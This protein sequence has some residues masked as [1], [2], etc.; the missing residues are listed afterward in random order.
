MKKHYLIQNEPDDFGNNNMGVIYEELKT[1]KSYVYEYKEIPKEDYEVLKK[2][3]LD[4]EEWEDYGYSSLK[5]F[6]E[7]YFC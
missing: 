1:F 5:E 6:I 2:Y 7:E 3:L 4:C